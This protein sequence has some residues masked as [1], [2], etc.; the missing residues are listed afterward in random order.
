MV[1]SNAGSEF[2]R[3]GWVHL[4]RCAVEGQNQTDPTKRLVYLE[5]QLRRPRSEI[6]LLHHRASMVGNQ[7]H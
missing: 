2:R 4:H 7:F 5:E 1:K 6:N 3:E